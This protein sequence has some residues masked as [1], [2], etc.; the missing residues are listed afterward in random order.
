MLVGLGLLEL[1]DLD[2]EA[3]DGDRCL[4][5]LGGVIERFLRLYSG[6][7]SRRRLSR[8]LLERLLR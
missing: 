5:G 6:E 3:G 2:F 8:G 7:D 1:G 4:R